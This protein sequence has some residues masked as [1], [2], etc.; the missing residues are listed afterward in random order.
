M[1][2]FQGIGTR[3]VEGEV[4]SKEELTNRYLT[5]YVYG[6]HDHDVASVIS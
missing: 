1:R 4:G 5:Y 2:K 6:Y 3:S